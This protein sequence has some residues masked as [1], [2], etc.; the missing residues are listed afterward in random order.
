MGKG[1]G[2]AAGHR[3]TAEAGAEALA[4][5]G[6]AVDAAVAAA[7]AAMVAEPV[8]AGLLGGGFAMIR[9]PGGACRLMD[10][11]VDTPARQRPEGEIDLR[12]IHADFGGVTQAFHIGAGT[13]AASP[14]AAGLWEAHARYG[15]LPMADLVAPAA[16][17]ARE[18]VALTAYQARL[19]RIIAPILTASAGA[20]AL[21]CEGAEAEAALKGEG[22]RLA[23]PE[24]AEVLE[25]FAREGPRFVAEG[26]VA[27][28]L[29]ALAEAG[30]HLTRADAA[31][32]RP[33]WRRPLIERRGGVEIALNPPPSLGG[34]LIGLS[35]ALLADRPGPAEIARAFLET[36]R[37]RAEAGLDAD[38]E[39]RAPALAD[40]AYRA[41][42]KAAVARPAAV[43]GTTHISVVD[44]SGLAVA[45][46]LSN[47]EGCGA[48][49]PGTGIMPNNM[50]GEADLVPGLAEGRPLAW[51][52][53]RRL[54]S[55][56]APMAAVWP[57]GRVAV[58]GSGGS[59]RIRTALAQ[60][61]LHLVDHGHPLEAAIEAPRLHLELAGRE[62]A[63][64]AEAE[65]LAEADRAALAEA[66]PE[67]R[68]WEARS[69]FFGGAHGAM[70]DAR[71]GVSAHGDSRRAG[72][73]ALS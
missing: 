58:L 45:L 21:H 27:A 28:G 3:L 41:R 65:G 17:A 10:A 12:E 59:N 70:R 26:E 34:T 38:P 66:F 42:L 64:D 11:F 15:R 39:A 35:L 19:A 52:P 69:M 36:A 62:A 51:T 72:H 53:G 20:R 2:I 73:A 23:N 57:D 1:H 46:T 61:L 63:V 8:L 5:G 31:G 49:I 43:R 14:L 6:T 13:I 68:F 29:A 40:P 44:A 56:M 47:G 4:A 37:A 67:T 60:T 9:E 32:V 55:M 50:L 16:A 7:F 54:A 22:A 25:E 24:F 30:G 48:V 18:G 33:V 71:G